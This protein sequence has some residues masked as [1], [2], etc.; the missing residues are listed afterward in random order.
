[1][2]KSFSLLELI[3]IVLSI[4]FLYTIFIPKKNDDKLT[5]ITKRLVLFLKEI[6]YKALIDNQYEVNDKNWYKKL[7]TLKFFRCDKNIGG[8]YFVAF[9]D[10]NKSGHPKKIHSLFE[11]LTKKRLYSSNDCKE[12]ENNSKYVLLTKNYNIKNVE[13]SCNETDSLGQVSFSNKSKVYTK[14]KKDK[15]LDRYILKS[16]CDIKI[17]NKEND[18][19]IITINNNGYI[20]HSF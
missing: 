19:K 18:Y 15:S 20:K 2:K 14:L 10:L 3:L 12:N 6:R 7:W 11:P 4:S 9:K 17:I 1:M 8:I 16:K 13:I 5:E